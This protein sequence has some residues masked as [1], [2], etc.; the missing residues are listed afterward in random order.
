[1]AT[2]LD[3]MEYANSAAAQEAYVS[4]DAVWDLLDE[5]CSAIDD[6]IDNDNGTGVSEVDPAGQFRFD[7]NLG[8]ALNGYANRYRDDLDSPPNKFVIEIKTYFDDIGTDANGDAFYFYYSTATW[9]FQAIFASDGL[10]ITKTGGVDVEVGA[11]IVKEGVSAAW[12]IWRF[13]VDKSGGEAAATVEV[14]LDDVSQGTV[15]CDWEVASTD[16]RCLLTQYGNTTDNMVCH[17]DWVRVATGIPAPHL[18]CYSESTI[19]TQGS[20]SL[21]GIAKATDSLNDTLT[22]TIASPIDLSGIGEVKY[23][24]YSDRT[25]SNIK[26]GIHDSGG[27][28]S[29]HTA[30]ISSAGAWETQTWN[31]SAISNANRD[32]IDSIIITVVNADADNTF[33]IDNF[34]GQSFQISVSECIDL[35]EKIGG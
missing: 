4:S 10:F 18:Q 32:D 8:A 15:D 26:I 19:K 3:L 30:N 6:W 33:Y 7:T 25:G 22:R 13:E 20:Y 1:M 5:N 29:E 16:G 23:G 17:I 11:D 27:T 14:F 34:F 2:T 21:K 28:T 24:I 9:R 31:L 12:Q 35:E